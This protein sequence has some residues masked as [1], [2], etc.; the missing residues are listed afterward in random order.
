MRSPTSTKVR[1][2]FVVSHP[3][4]YYVPL[5]QHLAR[6]DDVEIKVF[7]TWHVADKTN[8]DRGFRTSFT[9]DI[10]LTEGYEFELVPNISSDAGTHHYFGLRNPSLLDRLM[11][12]KPDAVHITGWAW[13]SHLLALRGLSKLGIPTLFRGD[14]HL[15]N[16]GSAALS[17]WVKRA[18]LCHVFS[19]P[20]VFLYTGSANRAYYEA[21]G[22]GPER[23]HYCPHSIDVSRFAEPAE[24][25]EQEARQWRRQLTID[26]NKIVLLFAGK[27]EPNKRPLHLMR[28]LLASSHLNLTLVLVGSG[29]LEPNVKQLAAAHPDRF[30]VLPFHNQTQMPMVYRLGDI[31]VM[32]SAGETWGLAV[33]E[34]MACARPVLV[35]DRVGC[36]VDVVDA[37][38][39]YVF[40]WR[41]PSGLY[42]ALQAID[43][44]RS[45]LAVMGRAAAEAAK[46]FD[47]S[48]T[49]KALIG[50]LTRVLNS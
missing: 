29:E 31:F 12:W 50:S 9:W 23:L 33:N 24:A 30:H 14:S 2:A 13:H 26:A 15:L 20:T 47:I 8:L 41:D 17:W 42:A 32:P 16:R 39:G 44:D 18:I 25:L 6:R 27:F 45:K 35:S 37:F 28:A 22:V 48:Q 3:I 34:A 43:W 21:F 49:E 36:A 10:P 1:L 19:W 7:F 38:S 5:Y 46:R 4:Q 11:A 40:S